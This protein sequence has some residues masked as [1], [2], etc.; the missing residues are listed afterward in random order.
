MGSCKDLDVETTRNLKNEEV[1]SAK[2]LSFQIVEYA[3]TADFKR[4]Q[5][6]VTIASPPL[7]FVSQGGFTG[8]YHV[9][10]VAHQIVF[11]DCG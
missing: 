5:G 10:Y 4:V 2:M 1:D 11:A 8:L 7:C 3:K 6:Q 9:A